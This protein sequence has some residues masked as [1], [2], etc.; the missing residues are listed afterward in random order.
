MPS[1]SPPRLK[2]NEKLRQLLQTGLQ[3]RETDSERIPNLS[4]PSPRIT[5]S[6]YVGLKIRTDSLFSVRNA[7]PPSAHLLPSL[8]LSISLLLS[9]RSST[10]CSREMRNRFPAFKKESVQTKE[11]L[12]RRDPRHIELSCFPSLASI[13]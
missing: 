1:S 7:F 6:V 3:F 4:S 2:L 5:N 9:L 12:E 11:S 13:S 10:S 8:F